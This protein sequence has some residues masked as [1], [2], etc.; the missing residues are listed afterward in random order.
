MRIAL[1]GPVYP[2]RG[3]MAHYTTMLYRELTSRGH[4]VLLISF[5]R[6]YPQW[7][8]PGKSDKDASRAAL[9]IEATRYWI[10]SMNPLT[11]LATAWRV[12]RYRPDVLILQWWVAF[13]TPVWLV[14]GG[15]F[16][17]LSRRPV[18]MLGHC[19]RPHGARW[20]D[21]V[22]AWLGLR[23]GSRFITHSEEEQARL[24][25]LLPRADVTVMSM[26]V[27]D[28]LAGET[29]TQREA[30]AHLGLP[31]DAPVMLFFGLIRP[32]KGLDDLLA[33]LPAVKA[34]VPDVKLVIAGEFWK[35]RER[36][37]QTIDDLGLR[38]NIVLD[39]RYIPD[40]EVKWY[41]SAADVVIL[42][43]REITGSAV[44]KLTLGFARPA[45]ATDVGGLSVVI[46][47]DVNGFLV[48]P[49]DPTALGEAIVRFFE[50]HRA[51]A[52]RAAMREH[53]KQF[54]WQP[55]MD[56]LEACSAD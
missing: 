56:V 24:L 14:L 13:W 27:F 44:A 11:W 42:P 9:K 19:I 6:Q 38:E 39:S 51:E 47:D 28:M 55:L 16:R 1:V 21:Q 37:M 36:Y 33:A 23:V 10:D 50:E 45:I 26:P 5:K 35:N 12:L 18:L 4:E 52:M 29:I 8:F 7:L 3:G 40:E 32:Y 49:E 22:L 54:S 41:F 2:Y 30:R 34:R 53:R 25:R 43:Y 20:W 15:L 46:E 48:P 17:L 31:P